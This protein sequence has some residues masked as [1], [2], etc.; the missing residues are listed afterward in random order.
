[1]PVADWA[2]LLRLPVLAPELR[3]AAELFRP[4]RLQA[5]AELV[6]PAQGALWLQAFDQPFCEASQPG[7]PEPV[8]AGQA[9]FPASLRWWSFLE[10]QPS[11]L[12]SDLKKSIPK[13][14]NRTTTEEEPSCECGF[15]A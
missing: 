7:R 2:V 9:L 11:C 12:C 4:E 10:E 13:K 5:E 6:Q 8:P 1:V 3:A 14:L 15:Y